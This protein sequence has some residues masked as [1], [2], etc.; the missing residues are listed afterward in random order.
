MDFDYDLTVFLDDLKEAQQM[1]LSSDIY[2]NL[3]KKIVRAENVPEKRKE[4]QNGLKL[5]IIKRIQS[6]N[7]KL[8]REYP[9]ELKELK[10]IQEASHDTN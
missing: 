5:L 7:S 4:Y 3:L 1:L 2:E 6:F 8:E 9:E 10:S